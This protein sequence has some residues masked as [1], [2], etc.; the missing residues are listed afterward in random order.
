MAVQWSYLHKLFM[1]AGVLA[2]V[3][4]VACGAAAPETVEVIR[5]VPV[6]VAVEKEVIREVQVEVPVEREVIKEVEVEKTVVETEI[7]EVEKEVQVE[8]EKILIATPTPAP[9]PAAATESVGHLR[10]TYTSLGSDG[11]YPK[12]SNVNAGGKD[13]NS[14]MYDVVVGSDAQGA[15]SKDTGIANDWSVSDDGKVHTINL[16]HGILFHNNEEVTSAD[17]MFSALEVMEE[18]AQNAFINELTPLWDSYETPDAHTFVIN[19][20]TPCLYAPWIFSGV[21]GTEGMVVPKAHYEA[22][23]ESE[24][25]KAPIGSG[26]YRFVEQVLGASVQVESINRPHFRGGPNG[27]IPK[28]AELT[29]LGVSEETTRIAM[30]K[31][32]QTDVIDVSRERIAPLADDGFNIFYKERALLS[33]MYFFQQWEEGNPFGDIRVR[34]ALNKAINRDA[35]LEHI[36]LGRGSTTLYPMGS[37][38]AANGYDP[39]QSAYPYDPDLSRQLLAEAGY[40][41]SNPLEIKL[42]IYAFGGIAEFPRMI[43]A[44]GADFEAVGVK[45]NFQPTEYGTLRS[46]RRSWSLGGGWVGPWGTHNRAAPAEILSIVRVLKHSEAPYTTYKNPEFDAI[47]NQA[48]ASTDPEEVKALIGQMQEHLL[49][50]YDGIPLFEV[51]SSFAAIP[52]ITYWNT[53]KDSYDNNVDSLFFPDLRW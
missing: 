17:V 13:V 2:L 43:E 40:T 53:G 46:M 50:N 38:A 36:F 47:M 26:P 29:F 19:C 5:E 51:D 33:G 39:A 11:I 23:G 6:E 1:L 34:E 42:A 10:V 35:I 27:G 52:E 31:S 49:A 22:I 12:A 45:V 18:D 7:R 44:I 24:F 20:H 3:F 15:F 9:P 30:L 41:E 16:R 21:R 48:F 32:G 14:S 37:Y 25:A 28:Y 4:I 8:V